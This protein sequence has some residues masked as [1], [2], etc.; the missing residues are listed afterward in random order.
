MNKL[1][2]T[3]ALITLTIVTLSIIP[4]AMLISIPVLRAQQYTITTSSSYLHNYSWIEIV[5]TGPTDWTE[6][7]F[8]VILK[9]TGERLRLWNYTGCAEV[10]YG[11]AKKY[12]PGVFVAYLGG[13]NVVDKPFYNKTD[14]IYNVTT[15]GAELTG[16]T[17]VIRVPALG[18]IS[19]EVKYDYAPISISFDRTTYG[20]LNSTWVRL[21]ITDP[22]WNL[23]P[24]KPDTLSSDNVNVT[25][26]VIN[27][28]GTFVIPP[29]GSLNLTEAIFKTFV[30]EA[31]ETAIN[32]GVFRFNFTLEH[33]LNAT[34][35]NAFK[36]GDVVKIKVIFVNKTDI[37]DEKSFTIK[38][39]AP[40]IDLS[41]SF[42]DEVT[43]VVNSPDNNLKS[44]AKDKL[45]IYYAIYPEGVSPTYT[46]VDIDETDVNTGVFKKTIDLDWTSELLGNASLGK[47]VM[48]RVNVSYAY[49]GKWVVKELKVVPVPPTVSIDKTEYFKTDT[50]KLVLRDPDLNDK[51]DVVEVY[52]SR[53]LSGGETVKD[54][55]L[56]KGGL[57][58][59][60]ISI[61]KLPE[62]IPVNVS[63]G[64]TL[65]LSL[66]ERY[67][68]PGVFDLKINLT[69]LNI[70]ED[71]SYRIKIGDNT[72]GKYVSV[73][74]KVIK[75]E[76]KVELDKSVYP[77]PKDKALTVRV[78]ITDPDANVNPYAK[79]VIS[80]GS[81]T[82]TLYNYTGGTE[83]Y[84]CIKYDLTETDVNTGVFEGKVTVGPIADTKMINGRINITYKGKTAEARFTVT[85][86]S[87]SVN[88]TTVKYGDYIKV[89]VV[90]PD[91]NLDS[92]TAEEV[93][94]TVAGVT[95]SL[96]E[97][98]TDSGV[99]EG[100][101]L[102]A[103]DGD[104]YADPAKDIEIKYSD[105]TPGYTTP[106]GVWETLE[107]SKT[108]KVASFTGSLSTDRTE[109]GPSATIKVTVT[110][111]DANKNVKLYDRVDVSYV[112]EGIVGTYTLTL[113][114]T[115]V[116]TGVFEGEID[117]TAI[118]GVTAKDLVGKRISIVYRDPADATGKAAT[119]PVVVKVISVDG[120][121]SFDKPYYNV[122]DVMKITVEDMDA[123]LKPDVIDT[124]T[125][126]VYSDTDPVGI[127]VTAS[128]TGKNTGIFEIAVLVSETPGAG[129]VAAKPGDKI[130]VEYE[131]KFP[132]DYAVTGKSKMIK[133]SVPVGVPVVKPITPKKADFIDP[134]TGV[135]V[136]PKVG[137]MVG[138]SVELSNVGVTDQVFTAI[139]VVKDPAGVVV[140]VDSISIPLAAGKSGTVTFSYIP[141][142]VGDYTVEVY[143]V[144]SLADWTPLGDMLTKVMSVVS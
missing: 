102:V 78:R 37:Y 65:T 96:K 3:L 106:G 132:A 79:D 19:T 56:S 67:E 46:S 140:K 62:E 44:W 41:G 33:I 143:V 139:L 22:N 111:W 6:V 57:N 95:K 117:L 59:L 98:A 14:A 105:T 125:I 23:D 91:A 137:S 101:F 10:D 113:E 50:I 129:R 68:E 138:I 70:T 100:V 66:I 40:T 25:I 83:T 21:I 124:V 8:E 42:S 82:C 12:A 11:I 116:S 54:V 81:V 89:T 74:F 118:P 36:S 131:D 4:A 92:K 55:I 127:T 49:E 30:A 17:L 26:T 34:G 112:I 84:P 5:I 73:D 28:T 15:P 77:L 48:V 38:S 85:S 29:T 47:A 1:T 119:I 39:V 53:T 45:T 69:K 16:K 20:P 135:S 121:I 88:V 120:V 144:K 107:L 141:K 122:G 60:N 93:S 94:V 13:K 133:E 136:I 27:A 76:V 123:N 63:S 97:T 32:N 126:R 104:V 99:F 51:K 58:Y 86:A 103:A 130:Y 35:G 142:L 90:D 134:K 31:D 87:L 128:E 52:T 9:D 110:D 18:F 71:T 7:L 43:V 115:D 72:S 61:L 108:V 75:K 64:E 24:T 2:K 114:E 80:G 109:Y